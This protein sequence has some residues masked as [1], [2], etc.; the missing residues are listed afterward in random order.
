MASASADA[1]K[2]NQE[3]LALR[4][5]KLGRDH[6]DT[7]ES[8]NNLAESY[9]RRCT[10]RRS[11]CGCASP[12]SSPPRGWRQPPR[13]R[14]GPRSGFLP[15]RAWPKG[16]WGHWLARET[17]FRFSRVSRRRPIASAANVRGPRASR[18][19][20]QGKIRVVGR[21]VQ[22]VRHSHRPVVAAIRESEPGRARR[23]RFRNRLSRDRRL[24]TS[25]S[26][27]PANQRSSA[28]EFRVIL[29]LSLQD[30]A[31]G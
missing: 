6:P 30:N 10:G 27:E 17:R 12:K 31:G 20:L 28:R 23:D 18:P 9:S 15:R 7:I 5:A 24:W 29:L 8:M 2:L 19:H 22:Q 3:T 26:T 16:Y 4:Q 14:D 11:R 25:A 13:G 1:F 21:A